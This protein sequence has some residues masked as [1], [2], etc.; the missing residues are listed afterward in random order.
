[1]DVPEMAQPHKDVRLRRLPADGSCLLWQVR[2]ISYKRSSEY[3]LLTDTSRQ[4]S[5]LCKRQP[6]ASKIVIK[7]T[8]LTCSKAQLIQIDSVVVCLS[9]FAQVCN[10]PLPH[11]RFTV[12]VAHKTSKNVLFFI[13]KLSQLTPT[14][15]DI[16]KERKGDDTNE[17]VRSEYTRRE[18]AE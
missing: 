8:H 10:K 16:S 15:S 1:M 3:L 14:L 9:A 2:K 4:L 12:S 11:V 7:E 17:R 18:H 6:H 5:K 13:T